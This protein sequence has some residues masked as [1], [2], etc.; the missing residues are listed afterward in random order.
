M[1][2][3]PSNKAKKIQ[4]TVDSI[5]DKINLAIFCFIKKPRLKQEFD[6]LWRNILLI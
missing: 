5:S 4:K 1:S 2:D 6:R 3:L